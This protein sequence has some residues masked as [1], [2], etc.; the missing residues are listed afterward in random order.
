MRNH[1]LLTGGGS[2]EEAF[3]LMYYFHKWCEAYV[4]C[5]YTTTPPPRHVVISEEVNEAARLADLANM[6]EGGMGRDVYEAMCRGLD[7][8]GLE[9]GYPYK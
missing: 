3:Y 1:G 2:I 7:D 9:T 6:P 5:G 8:A 4:D